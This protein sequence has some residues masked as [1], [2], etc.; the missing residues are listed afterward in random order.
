LPTRYQPHLAQRPGPVTRVLGII[1]QNDEQTLVGGVFIKPFEVLDRK[2][3]GIRAEPGAPGLAMHAGIHVEIDRERQFVVEQLVGSLYLNFRNGLNWTPLS[4]FRERDRGGWDLTVP[5]TTF[6]GVEP[7]HVAA[8]VRRLN[9]IQGHPF[10]GED[11]TAFIERS[12]GGQRLFAD[13]PL[14][15]AVGLAV[16]IGDPSLPLLDPDARL[17][18]RARALL[19]FD[20]V[21]SLPP[22]EAGVDSPNARMWLGRLAPALALGAILGWLVRRYSS[23]SR[24]STP[25]S[26]TA[27]K[28][29]R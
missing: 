22:A 14:L 1:F 29:F 3:A 11:C 24:R 13:S 2:I 28:F 27:R 26:R 20:G 18:A 16:R 8:A 7:A 9:S 15:R 23:V 10:V 25:A 17:D 6:R 4:K 12:F 19:Q 5:A 21:R